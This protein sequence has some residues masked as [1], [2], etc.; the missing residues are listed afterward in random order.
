[1]HKFIFIG[2]G[3]LTLVIGYSSFEQI[4]QSNK[5]QQTS[6]EDQK[7]STIK[8]VVALKPISRG[9]EFLADSVGYHDWPIN[10]I[11]P[12]TI[13]D[14]NEAIGQISAIDIVQG[15][16]IVRSMFTSSPQGKT[17]MDP[18]SEQIFNRFWQ[19]ANVYLFLFLVIAIVQFVSRV[20]TIFEERKLARLEG[21]AKRGVKVWTE[22][23]DKEIVELLRAIPHTLQ[24][25]EKFIYKDDSE[26]LIGEHR[27]I[28]FPRGMYVGY[29]DL[30]TSEN[31]LEYR[32]AVSRFIERVITVMLL[33]FIVISFWIWFFIIGIF[34]LA[35][36]GSIF[37]LFIIAVFLIGTVVQH[38]RERRR[39]LGI[40]NQ[41]KNLV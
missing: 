19:F 10:N 17:T 31:R 41:A 14:K 23:I 40:V 2:L 9:E 6:P 38:Y 8:V 30:N 5:L 27:R 26:V 29:M 22:T 20:W 15:Q 33:L 4:G 32:V 36:M 18:T 39:L 34:E 7:V 3:F 25:Q 12:D 13:F 35:L 24:L 28:F 21:A 1:M 11:P 37:W 16:L